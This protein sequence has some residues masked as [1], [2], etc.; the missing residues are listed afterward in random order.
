MFSTESPMKERN[1]RPSSTTGANAGWVFC[2][3]LLR[4]SRDGSWICN[5]QH[6]RPGCT[7][8]LMKETSGLASISQLRM[9]GLVDTRRFQGYHGYFSFNTIMVKFFSSEMS[10]TLRGPRYPPAPPKS[11]K[12]QDCLLFHCLL[13]VWWCLL[14]RKCDRC[15]GIEKSGPF[16][17][18][19][20]YNWL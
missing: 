12:I 15:F 8:L 11:F 2:F 20:T 7:W 17:I 14:G 9:L 13:L 10:M 6:S 1:Q 18:K 16:I 3:A 4:I 19:C 5:A